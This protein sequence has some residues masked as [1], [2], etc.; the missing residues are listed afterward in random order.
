MMHPWVL[1]VFCFDFMLV[2]AW[3][4]IRR[5]FAQFALH[6]PVAESFKA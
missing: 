1:C 6:L 5:R 3:A 4:A 2:A